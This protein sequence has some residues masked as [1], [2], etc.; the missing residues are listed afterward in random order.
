[1]THDAT[2]VNAERK[3]RTD[4]EIHTPYIVFSAINS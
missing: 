2:A 4:L 3:D 1:M